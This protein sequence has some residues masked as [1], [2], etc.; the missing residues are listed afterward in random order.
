MRAKVKIYFCAE[1]LPE[2]RG[3]SPSIFGAK[4]KARTTERRADRSFNS[5]GEEEHHHV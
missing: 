2:N 4:S 5:T 1:E 3:Q